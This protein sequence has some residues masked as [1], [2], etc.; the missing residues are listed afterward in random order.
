MELDLP[1]RD[2]PSRTGF[3]TTPRGIRRW[4]KEIAR[5][6]VREATRRFT[7]GMRALNRLEVPPRTRARIMEM[8]RPTGREVLDHLSGRVHAQSLPLP[9]RTRKVFELNLDLLRELALGY[10]I[11]LAADTGG[12]QPGPAR[13]VAL[14]SE[15]SLA[16]RGEIMLR[17]AQVYAP[18]HEAFW[19][20]T[21]AVYALAEAAGVA[22]RAVADVELVE[23]EGRRQSAR[24]MYK[25]VL[26]FAVAQTDGLR[27]GDSERIYRALEEWADAAT[28]ATAAETAAA[29][30]DREEG[31]GEYRFAVDLAAARPPLAWRLLPD[32]PAETLR[33]L[34]LQ[35]VLDIVERLLAEAE[36]AE[37]DS[38][39][40]PDRISAVALRRLADKWQER[41]LRRAERVTRGEPVEVETT[42]PQIHAR[43]APPEPP[44]AEEPD[45]PGHRTDTVDLALQ[46]IDRDDE[47]RDAGYVTHP[48]IA[49][50]DR[51]GEAWDDVAAGRARAP[52]FVQ[53]RSEAEREAVERKARPDRPYWLLEDSSQ[54]GF[55]LRW[56]GE[57]ASRATVGELIALCLDNGDA[58]GPTWRVG[59]I[60]WMQFV[61]EAQFLVGCQA[62][63]TQVSAAAVRRAPAN[64]NRRRRREQEPTEPALLL[65][66][67]RAKGEPATLV[68]PAYMFRDGEAVELDVRGKTLRIVLTGMRE[69]T[70]SF[71][72]FGIAPAPKARPA[73]NGGGGVRSVWEAL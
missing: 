54:T 46:T 7:E 13:R 50:D 43:L 28:L 31:E 14:A 8:L 38:V 26:L 18:L 57:G 19:R 17:S 67:T 15:R 68:L 55:R 33:V 21:H 10:E 41:P 53:A 66:G 12:A 11:I 3:A 39:V 42:L 22:D 23:K 1:P 49:G 62:L 36:A 48:G 35:P 4:L 64:P 25:R 70:G 2:P 60:R 5:L 16:A 69:H 34:Q 9:E 6:E 71:S 65:P 24:T 37:T 52:G 59:V 20:Q 30:A 61:D 47:R 58:R 72:Q 73:G 27:K 44:E 63:S 56:A 29:D 32:A 45:A 40:D 51:A